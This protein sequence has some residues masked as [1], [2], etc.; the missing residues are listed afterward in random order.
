V[1]YNHPGSDAGGPFLH[2][3]PEWIEEVWPRYMKIVPERF[4]GDRP[5]VMFITNGLVEDKLYAL[6]RRFPIDSVVLAD[7]FFSGGREAFYKALGSRPRFD[8]FVLSRVNSGHIPADV[9]YEI[10]RRVK[11]EGTGL[12]IIDLFDH[13]DILNTRFLGLKTR[14]LVIAGIPYEGLRRLELSES[15][16][17]LSYNF[18]FGNLRYSPVE[19]Q[20]T[21]GKTTV[22]QLGKGRVVFSSTGTHWE[23]RGWARTLL[24]HISMNRSMWVETD[25]HYSHA[26]KLILLASGYNPVV[27]VTDITPKGISS[28]NETPTVTLTGG[29]PFRGTLRW[30]IRDTWGKI[31]DCGRFPLH[32]QK[33]ETRFTLT[34]VGFHDAGRRFL[35]LWVENGSGETVDWGSTFVFVDRGVVPPE[36]TFRYPEGAP[37]GV[38]LE[39]TVKAA[40]VPAGARIR[41]TLVDRYWREVGLLEEPAVPGI[42][43][44]SFLSEGLDGQIW[45]VQVDVLDANGRVLSQ[46]YINITSPKTGSTREGFHPL[47]TLLSFPSPEGAAHLEFFRRLGFL[48]NRPYSSGDVIQ[49]ETNAWSDIQMHP[50]FRAVSPDGW[51]WQKDRI[52]DWEEPHVEREMREGAAFMTSELKRFGHRGFNLTDD[53]SAARELC[54]GAYTAVGFHSWL[55]SE[56]GGLKET[57]NLWGWKEG[58]KVETPEGGLPYDP[59]VIKEFHGWLKKKYGGITETAAAWKIKEPPYFGSLR[60]FGIVEP[61][62]LK[63]LKDRGNPLPCEDARTF[64][65]QRQ[66]DVDSNPWGVI[67]HRSIKKSYE[68][69]VTAPMID[70]RRFLDSRWIEYMKWI[71]ESAESINSDAAVGSD[72]GFYRQALYDVAGTVDYFA[73]YHR[74]FEVNVGISRGRMYRDGYFGSCLGSYGEKP[75]MMYGRRSQIWDVLFSGGNSIYY[76]MMS[77]GG[78]IEGG[79]NLSDKHARYQMEVLEEITSGIGELFTSGRRVFDPVAVLGSETSG[80]CDELEKK[81]KPIVTEYNSIRAFHAALQDA[82]INPHFIT[83]DELAGDW[84]SENHTKLLVLPGT[85]SLSDAEASTIR[86]FVRDGGVVVADVRPGI[87]FPNGNLRAHPALDDIFGVTTDSEVSEVQVRGTLAGRALADGIPIMDFGTALADPRV[88]PNTSRTFGSIG[89]VPVLMVNSFGNGRAVLFNASFA[90]YATYRM[91]GGEI[92]QP[93]YEVIKA[94][95]YLAGIQGEFNV[96]SDGKKTPGLGISPFR[97]GEGYL[98]GIADLG[99]GD[100]VGDRRP[101]EFFLPEKMHI[102]EVRS[103]RYLGRSNTLRDE[104]PQNGHRAYALMPYE[105]TGVKISTDRIIVNHGDTISLNLDVLSAGGFRGVHVVRL[106]AVDP[107]GRCFFPFRKVLKLH[108]GTV[109][110]VP[111]TVAHN[112]LPGDWRFIATD[113]NS[114]KST[115]LIVN[116]TGKK[117]VK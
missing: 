104:L 2:G 113:I 52:L 50:Y 62:M 94:V 25:Y 18:W 98:V 101:F 14:E 45:R 77:A 106:E 12:L 80:L 30:Q 53:S 91:E 31:S 108:S 81:G 56:Y 4:A 55:Q 41:T 38:E 37:R 15:T 99:C 110:R 63:I 35:D 36:I 107:E 69:G 13:E 33:G 79:I 48:S 87:R 103:G 47:G 44:Y 89:K 86:E 26:V 6:N 16:K 114:G 75:A 90:S 51:D 8:C 109:L 23:R 96:T 115:S 3:G 100:F 19:K 17:Y 60:G 65:A 74:N 28:G 67:N 40:G 59:Y 42:V 46:G 95:L 21:Y 54:P 11:E 34:E 39:G 116:V 66:R 117:A 43:N 105:V 22:S 29:S 76:W 7:H 84:L 10:L 70:A 88:K 97:L 92:W 20:H 78:G 83:D 5:T 27:S 24:P 32:L 68:A 9:K 61:E 112:D 49:A 73:P 71:K 58:F 57:L 82:I 64:M 1:G 72:A 93:W 85:N 102:Y 111:L